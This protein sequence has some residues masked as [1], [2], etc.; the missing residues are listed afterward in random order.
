MNKIWWY[1]LG[2]A[3]LFYLLFKK[4]YT[5]PV[6]PKV[7]RWRTM[8]QKY[9]KPE[10]M[11]WAMAVLKCESGGNPNAVNSSTQ[12]SG[13]YQHIPKYF[14]SR[15]AAA[16]FPG[17][18]IFNPEANIAAAAYLFYHGG[19]QHWSCNKESHIGSLSLTKSQVM[20]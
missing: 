9:F 7:E 18:S 2:S 12:A 5:I 17:A 20:V 3:G 1:V 13:L 6:G 10:H 4:G 19:P 14:A 15:A 8:V 11:A 16:G